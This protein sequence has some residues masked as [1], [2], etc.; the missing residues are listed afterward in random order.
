MTT[1]GVDHLGNFV[2]GVGPRSALRNLLKPKTAAAQPAAITSGAGAG[3]AAG[4]HTRPL[5][6]S[7]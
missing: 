5:S 4:G 7:T 1:G 3:A 2:Q 6:S